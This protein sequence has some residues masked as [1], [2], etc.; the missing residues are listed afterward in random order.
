MVLFYLEIRLILYPVYPDYTGYFLP[1]D[2]SHPA[3]QNRNK[4][5]LI[6]EHTHTLNLSFTH[7]LIHTATHASNTHITI[8]YNTKPMLLSNPSFWFQWI[9]WTFLRS[10][11]LFALINSVKFLLF[12]LNFIIFCL[13]IHNI[14]ESFHGPIRYICFVFL[15]TA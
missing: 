12:D 2:G 6:L 7:T 11:I 8:S 10:W 15:T 3:A 5:I 13:N 14:H 4:S 9:F 1:R